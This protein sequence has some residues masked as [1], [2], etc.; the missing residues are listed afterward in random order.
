MNKIKIYKFDGTS[1]CI[2]ADELVIDLYQNCILVNKYPEV[3][4][5]N[6]RFIEVLKWIL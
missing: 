2:A 1:Q 4:L 3:E 6:I 5:E